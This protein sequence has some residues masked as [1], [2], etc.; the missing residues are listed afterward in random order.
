MKFNSNSFCCNFLL[1]LFLSLKHCVNCEAKD[2]EIEVQKIKLLQRERE[3]AF[4][5]AQ[6]EKG[7][8][9]ERAMYSF[10]NAGYNKSDVEAAARALVTLTVLNLKIVSCGICS[11]FRYPSP[12]SVLF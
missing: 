1:K 3:I 5:K 4:K 11:P 7:E 9:L 10:Y 12:S 6:L 2:K 8:S